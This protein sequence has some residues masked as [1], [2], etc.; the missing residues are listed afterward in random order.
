MENM[1]QLLSAVLL[2]L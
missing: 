1:K 2:H